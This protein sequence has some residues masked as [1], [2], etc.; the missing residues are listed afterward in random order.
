VS[1]EVVLLCLVIAVVG[2][3]KLCCGCGA[4]QASSRCD[5]AQLAAIAAAEIAESVAACRG[6]T[7]DT[8][9]ALPAIRAKY[10][11]QREEWVRCH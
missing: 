11:A 6:K 2:L 10:D 4:A 1:T 8:C 9:E 7:V 5:D 3:G